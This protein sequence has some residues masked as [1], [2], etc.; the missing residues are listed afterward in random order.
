MGGDWS[1]SSSLCGCREINARG[2]EW[3]E[4]DT[5]DGEKLLTHLQEYWKMVQSRVTQGRSGKLVEISLGRVSWYHVM[6]IPDRYLFLWYSFKGD[7]EA[8]VAPHYQSRP[9][10][11][12]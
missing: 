11:V 6:T 7:T 10:F 4:E 3:V 1:E 12:R 8:W 9:V 5:K 2:R